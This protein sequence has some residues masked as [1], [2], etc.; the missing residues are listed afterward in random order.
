VPQTEKQ[1]NPKHPRNTPA[2]LISLNHIASGMGS[3]IGV[4]CFLPTEPILEPHG[5]LTNPSNS[6]IEDF[7]KFTWD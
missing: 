4:V 3:L 1:K 2:P 5:T 7:K 6:N